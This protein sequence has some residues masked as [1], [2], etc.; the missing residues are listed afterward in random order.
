MTPRF[1]HK[2]YWTAT[3][4]I[5]RWQLVA[6]YALVITVSVI[7]FASVRHQNAKTHRVA[8]RAAALVVEVQRQRKAVCLD[9]NRRHDRTIA[10][11]DFLIAH[12]PPRL[13]K[14]AAASRAGNVTLIN[15]LAPRRNCAAINP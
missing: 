13:R 11:L 6:V 9:Q 12:V 15:A 1:F 5:P 8:Q 4:V 3:G 10:K 7:G 2:R 14:Q